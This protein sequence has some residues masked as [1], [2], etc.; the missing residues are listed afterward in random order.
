MKLWSWSATPAGRRISVEGTD[1]AGDVVK[2]DD[3][4]KIETDARSG[5]RVAIRDDD[6]EVLLT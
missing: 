3:V 5:R 2:L 1:D 4:V 6:E